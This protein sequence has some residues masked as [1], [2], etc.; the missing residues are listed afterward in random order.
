M[1]RWCLLTWALVLLVETQARIK[2]LVYGGT[3]LR[4]NT[5]KYLVFIVARETRSLC[6]GSIINSMTILTAAHCFNRL[7]SKFSIKHYIIEKFIEIA[8]VTQYGVIIHPEY[9][10]KLMN[11]DV[12]LAIMKTEENI[13]FD[14]CVQ[15]IPLALYPRVQVSDKAIIAGF[16]KADPTGKPEGREGKVIITS[17]PNKYH[18]M[19]CTL[20][21]VRAAAGDSGGALVYRRQLVGVTSGSCMYAEQLSISNPCLTVFANVTANIDWILSQLDVLTTTEIPTTT[22]DTSLSLPPNTS[23]IPP[24]LYGYSPITTITS[25]TRPPINRS[26]LESLYRQLPVYY[27]NSMSR[28]NFTHIFI[29]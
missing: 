10:R 17:C 22:T 4:Y 2:T 27:D 21:F 12:D 7:S 28:T 14:E 15:P 24:K 19:I 3:A 9:D 8:Y 26:G 23:F 5:H 16:G 1:I 13:E 25:T 6:S 29:L 18:N 11:R 20:G